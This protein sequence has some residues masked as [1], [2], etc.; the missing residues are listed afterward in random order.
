MILDI[1]CVALFILFIVIGVKLGA[2]RMLFGLAADFVSYLAASWISGFA[3]A[4]IYTAFIRPTVIKS[5]TAA[6][7]DMIIGRADSALSSLPWWLKSAIS[8]TGADLSSGADTL[9]ADI[10]DSI[11][12]TVNTAVQP[13]IT[14]F[15][16]ILLTLILYLLIRFILVKLFKKPLVKIF[17]LPVIGTVNKFFGAV[18]GAIE[19]LL[20]IMMLAYLLKLLL[21]YIG[22]EAWIIDETTI[23]NSLIFYHFY[24]GN[25]FTALSLWITG[26]D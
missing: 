9:Y 4:H 24:S 22:T 21:P 7:N 11:A 25:I 3:A 26:I 18:L 1:F 5:I 6:S 12:Q 13:I 19:S 15:L 23:Y 14:G 16:S 17:E 2:F 8:L 20:I 10:S